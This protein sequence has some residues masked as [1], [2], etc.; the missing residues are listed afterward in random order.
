MESIGLP[1]VLRR[2]ARETARSG[3][4]IG[5]GAVWNR[6]GAGTPVPRIRHRGSWGRGASGLRARMAGRVAR[7]RDTIAS[8]SSR[9]QDV[10]LSR[11]KRGFESRWGRQLAFGELA[12]PTVFRFAAQ[13]LRPRA[14]G[15]ES[16]RRPRVIHSGD[17]GNS[18]GA[19]GFFSGFAP[20]SPGGTR[21][22]GPCVAFSRRLESRS[23]AETPACR[24]SSQPRSRLTRSQGRAGYRRPPSPCSPR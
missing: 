20:A 5:A 16:L 22:I 8:P 3:R 23:P 6:G 13:H 9:G 12:A 18:V 7:R 11:P 10:A 17:A 24:R 1:S 4:R 2:R 21:A 14:S 19:N 15:T